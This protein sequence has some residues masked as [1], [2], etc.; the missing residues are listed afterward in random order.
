M[1][2]L[3]AAARRTSDQQWSVEIT[4]PRGRT[5]EFNIVARDDKGRESEPLR[6]TVSP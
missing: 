2:Q 4:L 6:V 1:Q 5:Y 3:P